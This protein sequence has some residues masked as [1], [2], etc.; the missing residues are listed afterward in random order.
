MLRARTAITGV[1]ALVFGV[2][3]AFTLAAP[4]N[5]GSVL[6]TTTVINVHYDACLSELGATAGVLIGID[7]QLQFEYRNPQTPNI[8]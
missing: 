8:G 2:A 4:A 7:P 1:A 6:G 3:S 5:A